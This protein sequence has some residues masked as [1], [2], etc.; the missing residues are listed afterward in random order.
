L[1][2]KGE[3]R[4]EEG[5]GEGSGRRRGRGGGRSGKVIYNYLWPYSQHTQGRQ[6]EFIDFKT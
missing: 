5:R 2:Q 3:R 4:E 1:K 6:G